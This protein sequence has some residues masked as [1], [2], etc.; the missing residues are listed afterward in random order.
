MPAIVGIDLGTTF[1]CVATIG[2]NGEPEAIANFEG[3]NTTPSVVAYSD[4]EIYIGETAVQSATPTTNI[5]HVSSNNC[6]QFQGKPLVKLTQNGEE[7]K[8]DAEEV[9]AEVLKMMKKIAVKYLNEEVTKA[10]VT[11]PA[12]FDQRQRHATVE[13]AKLAGIEV[14]RLLNEPTA[15]AIAYGIHNEGTNNVLV[16]DL[17]GGIA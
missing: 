14:I 12:N 16:Y 7:K 15:A 4:D 1:S 5:I 17:G 3:A 11:V 9:S 13:A 6:D 8:L 10:V 2:P